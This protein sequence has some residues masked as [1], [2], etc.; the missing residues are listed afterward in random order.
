MFE[1]LKQ[2]GNRLL[3]IDATHNTTCLGFKLITCFMVDP[4]GNCGLPVCFTIAPSESGLYMNAMFQL[5]QVLSFH[6][7]AI[8]CKMN[9]LSF[10]LETEFLRHFSVEA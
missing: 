3:A 2:F 5:T 4:H 9:V 6:H 10:S 8:N 1:N 7:Y